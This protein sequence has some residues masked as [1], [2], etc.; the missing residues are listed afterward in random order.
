MNDISLSILFGILAALLIIS[1]F[2]S[3]SETALM[4]LNRYRLQHLV[5]K[6]HK[7]AIKAHQLLK[8]P[9]RLLGLIL[10][11]NNFVN[12]L[13]SSLTTLI[14]IRVSGDNAIAPAIGL[15]AFGLLV[16][17]EVTP[18]TLGALKP[19]LLALLSSWIYIPL[20]KI[21]YPL[22][23][24]IN[25]ISSLLLWPFGIKNT[26]NTTLESLNK[27]EL[28]SIVSD[29]NHLP[30]RYQN[31]LLSILDLESASVTDI[32]T[33]RNEIVGIDLEESVE[34]IIEQLQNSPHTRLPVYKK[35][36]DRVI[37]FLHLR[38]ILSQ[39]SD[40]DFDKH[41]ITNSLSKPFFIPASTS[42]HKQMQIFKA[43]KLRIGLVV[44]EYGDVQGLVTLDDLLQ[45][46]VGELVSE[47][48][49]IKMQKDGSYLVD[50]GVTIREL[51]RIT[52]WDLPTEGPKTLN[53]LVIEYMETIP[54]PGTSVKLHGHI[55][56]II[57]R[58]EN[59]I[60]LIKFNP[61]R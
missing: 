26:S 47:E 34:D 36:I 20:L 50:A 7:G 46:I 12:I 19:E 27:D 53:G 18:K 60:K 52:H 23:W 25:S 56:E 38:T 6:N 32:M 58:D 1:A 61:K 5:K 4:T 48:P 11:G 45:E 17:S 2:F 55:I 28:K 15:L 57:K 35:N 31:M 9:D 54:E 39:I 30:A 43:E 37:G 10:L 33:H 21:F 44:D 59:A 3:G 24:V 14:A 41:N 51:N 16:F 49:D 40:P 29:A 42:I 22:V 13:A 8:R